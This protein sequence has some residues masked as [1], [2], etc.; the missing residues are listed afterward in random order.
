MSKKFPVVSLA[1]FTNVPWR[2]DKAEVRRF[3]H[4]LVA[5]LHVQDK[6]EGNHILYHLYEPTYQKLPD[7][8]YE[9][10]GSQK[11]L[12]HNLLKQR[13]LIERNGTMYHVS[14]N[15]HLYPDGVCATPLYPSRHKLWKQAQRERVREIT[16]IVF[17]DSS[18]GY[19]SDGVV[20][21]LLP[22]RLTTY[23]LDDLEDAGVSLEG[24]VGW[25]VTHDI[26]GTSGV[27][28]KL[29]SGKYAVRW[30]IKCAKSGCTRRVTILTKSGCHKGAYCYV[31]DRQGEYLAD[32]R[33]QQCVC[34][35]HA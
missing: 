8:A 21:E 13:S 14:G 15:N 3:G 17:P 29:K 12:E 25:K 2:A 22:N 20:C 34:E 27:L 35:H 26:L 24:Y 16:Q 32:L 1:N 18:R 33:N 9:Q 19:L 23:H 6:Y 30:K 11:I 31:C 7:I 28:L 5:R 10:L 4:A